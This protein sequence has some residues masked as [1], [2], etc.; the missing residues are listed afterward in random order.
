MKAYTD[1]SDERL[2]GGCAYCKQ[3]ATT[4]DHV[5]AKAFL[6]KPYPTNL[7][8]VYSCEECNNGLSKDEAYVAYLVKYM[9]D[10]LSDGE[11]ADE[12]A[13]S[14]HSDALEE[15]ITN[16]ITID[17]EGT[18]I[19]NLETERIK[20]V[21]EKFSIAHIQYELGEKKYIKPQISFA[22]VDQMAD[23]QIEKFNTPVADGLYP[24]IGSRLMQR[25]VERGDD[26]IIV[27]EN[28]YRYYIHS[29]QPISIRIVIGELLY[30]EAI[31]DEE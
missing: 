26:W 6:D 31:W 20:N 17:E 22:F 27:Q 10:I 14:A 7:H 5:P 13:L 3:P 1:F 30:C 18:P 21:I 29:G 28:K 23:A 25:V 24:E 2:R 11:D 4:R 15:R 16:S 8:L 12:E 19:I 9:N